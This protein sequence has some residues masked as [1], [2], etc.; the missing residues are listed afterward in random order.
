MQLG[1]V[2][3]TFAS[4]DKAKELLGVTASVSIEEGVPR[5]IEW[6]RRYYNC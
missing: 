3:A 4:T 5:F 2:P 6:Y 1:D